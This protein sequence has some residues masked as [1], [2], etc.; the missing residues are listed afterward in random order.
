[1]KIIDHYPEKG[2]IEK[3]PNLQAL[4]E[5]GEKLLGEDFLFDSPFNNDRGH[6]SDIEPG[7]LDLNVEDVGLQ[8]DFDL[9]DSL[10]DFVRKIREEDTVET[11]VKWI[12]RVAMILLIIVV[13]IP[14]CTIC[15]MWCDGRKY[16]DKTQSHVVTQQKDS[17]CVLTKSSTA[18]FNMVSAGS[19]NN[20]Q[21]DFGGVMPYDQ[22]AFS[23]KENQDKDQCGNI[24][25]KIKE[26]SYDWLIILFGIIFSLAIVAVIIVLAI[27][28]R[29]KDE[30]EH[31]DKRLFFEHQNK[32]IN[33]YANHLY[34]LKR[35]KLQQSE[36]LLS[37]KQQ[38]A[39]QQLDFQQQEMDMRQKEQDNA[40]KHKE[41]H[42]NA[43]KEHLSNL[44]YEANHQDK[45]EK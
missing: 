6:V 19:Q 28:I 39:L 42:Q 21:I 11:T 7:C 14:F 36:T 8:D 25:E 41:N 20:V 24:V 22:N 13:L 9:S 15:Y 29:K 26:H 35:V 23:Q 2:E 45:C 5:H 4:I 10:S 44:H 31:E 17:S 43:V 34:S 30:W 40:W 38:L 27:N 3:D 37:L 33:E 16:Q 1:M 18:N 32:M 12:D